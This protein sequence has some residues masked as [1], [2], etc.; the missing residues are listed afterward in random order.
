MRYL[1][2]DTGDVLPSDIALWP[3]RVVEGVPTQD[4]GNDCGIFVMK[5]MAVSLVEGPVDWSSQKDWGGLKQWLIC[6]FETAGQRGD[7]SKLDGHADAS[8]TLTFSKVFLSF[9]PSRAPPGSRS[10]DLADRSI[11][12]L[13]AIID[14]REGSPASA[15]GPLSPR[16]RISCPAVAD[17]GGEARRIPSGSRSGPSPLF[18]LAPVSLDRCSRHRSGS[19]RRRL[20]P[21]IVFPRRRS[22]QLRRLGG[23]A[24]SLLSFSDFS[25]SRFRCSTVVAD[26]KKNKDLPDLAG[27]V[28]KKSGN[29]RSFPLSIFPDLLREIDRCCHL[30]FHRRR[31]LII[32]AAGCLILLDPW[33]CAALDRRNRKPL[34]PD[35]ERGVFR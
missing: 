24:T 11:P 9:C 12:P 7:H 14:R 25:R 18:L 34:A 16:S 31:C 10:R 32:A 22:S 27:S 13:Y 6:L 8:S 4:N 2:E 5:Y 23:S 19:D 1:Q 15:V 35:C 29:C 20:S 26:G 28:Q 3:L 30:G 17:R 33:F 21:P